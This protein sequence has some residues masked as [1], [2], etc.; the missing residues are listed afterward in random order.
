M[1]M[2][3][4]I[5]GLRVPVIASYIEILQWCYSYKTYPAFGMPN[6][7]YIMFWAAEFWRIKVLALAL[8]P[9]GNYGG[10]RDRPWGKNE[11]TGILILKR[12]RVKP[13]ALQGRTVSLLGGGQLAVAHAGMSDRKNEHDSIAEQRCKTPWQRAKPY[14]KTPSSFFVV[15]PCLWVFCLTSPSFKFLHFRT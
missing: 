1:Y 12:L 8:Y 9:E 7:A 3:D 6:N 5:K 10:L 11:G 4:R 15:A 2:Y 13:N 14:M